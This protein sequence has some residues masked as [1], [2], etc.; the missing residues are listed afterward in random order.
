M[1]ETVTAWIATPPAPVHV[2]EYVALASSAPVDWVPLSALEPLQGPAAL[3]LVAL[4]AVQLRVAEPPLVTV[5]GFAPKLIVG[6]GAV[7]DT[8]AVCIAVPPGPVQ[9]NV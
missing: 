4:L 8:V 7:T 3:Q 9:L 1:T 5:L 6:V 2:K